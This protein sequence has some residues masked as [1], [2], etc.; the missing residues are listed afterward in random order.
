MASWF[1]LQYFEDSAV[2]EDAATA[3]DFP[4]LARRQIL[5]KAA[6]LADTRN[7]DARGTW[8]C[9]T[10]FDRERLVDMEAKI[11]PARA[12]MFGCL[13][14]GLL[15]GIPWFG[16]WILVPL[17]WV[18]VFYRLL[19]PWIAR[20][21]RPEYPIAVSV[22]HAQ[23]MLGIA[24]ALTGGPRSPALPM[25]LLGV[26]T[27]PAR[28]TARGVIAGVALTVV[29]L[30][31]ATVGVDPSGY[32]DD[33]TYVNAALAT[34][35]GLASI[36]Y[37]LMHSERQQRS[38]A[39]LDPLTG[40][41]NRKALMDRFAEIAEQAALTGGWVSL[42]ACDLDHFKAIN[43]EYGH[44][45]GDAVLKDAAYVIRRTLRSFELVYRT[46]GEEFLI[47]LPGATREDAQRLAER[48]RL[49][50]EESQPGGMGVTV[51]M[52]VAAAE[53]ADVV[54]EPLFRSADK[55]LY[56]A[57]REGRN[58]VVVFG[59]EPAAALVRG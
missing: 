49:G 50:V 33:P 47:V 52:G 19:T 28:F 17:A 51:S 5:Q 35:G 29:V 22:V 38:D 36:S 53:A 16:W 45:R 32:A 26:V 43:D 18:V 10:A 4:G 46:G 56:R 58:R 6:F 12:L 54:F 2:P 48:A 9:P 41:L 34:L 44:E 23:V 37:V 8:L 7:M 31:A 21:T 20:S 27:L 42:V 25:L 13:G 15:S 14:I 3:Q 24:V 57:K 30:L 11:G 39:I 1:D 55:A 59:A 40:L